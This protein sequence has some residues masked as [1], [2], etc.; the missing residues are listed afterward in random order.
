MA[1]AL[2]YYHNFKTIKDYGSGDEY[3]LEIYLEGYGGGSSELNAIE[4]N[5][6]ELSR[7]GDLLENVLGTKLTF[8]LWNETEGQFSEFRTAGWGDYMVKLIYDPSGVADEKFIGYNQ[9]E[10]YT[11]PYDQPPYQSKIEF[12]CGLSHLKHVRFDNSGT[13]YTG[14]KTIIEVLR[15]ALN[16][17]PNPVKI[18]EFVN[19]YEDSINSTTT[20][21]PFNQVYVDS[22]I[23]K[24]AK[25]DDDKNNEVGMFCYKVIEEIL[26]PFGA[27]IFTADGF[28]YIIRSQEYLDSTMYYREFNANVGTESTVTVDATGSFTTNNRSVTGRNGAANELVLQAQATEMSIDPP[29][30]RVKLTYDPTNLDIFESNLIKNGCW[31][32]TTKTPSGNTIKEVPDFWTIIGSSYLTY[33]SIITYVDK[34]Y[35]F[36]PTAQA[37]ATTADYNV[38]MSQ[39]KTGIPTFQTDSIQFS[40]DFVFVARVDYVA[41]GNVSN[42]PRNFLENNMEFNW[43]VELRFGSYYLSGDNVN[44]FSWTT[45]VSKA[46]FTRIGM[47]NFSSAIKQKF[48]LT[49]TLPTMPEDGLRDM[50]F[51][52]YRPYTNWASYAAT[53]SD[54]TMTFNILAQKCITLT[55]LPDELPPINE[56][57]L[58]SEI[59]E[60]ENLEDITTMHGDGTT[61]VSLN[62]YRLS[63]G[64]ITD[65]WNR[66][67]ISDSVGILKIL[68]YQLR[69][70]RS[71][72]LK[73]LSGRVIA[74]M[75]FYNTI[76][77]SAGGSVTYWMRTYSWSPELNEWDVDLMELRNDTGT[78]TT[79][80]QENTAIPVLLDTNDDS[81]AVDPN[82]P[83]STQ[84]IVVASTPIII[85][86]NNTNN[87]V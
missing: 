60:D 14:Q 55:Y 77:D 64:T 45:V 23:Y 30:N 6:I 84:S 71:Q 75:D 38:Y 11:E 83:I 39:S 12:T 13:L 35:Q 87:F 54:Y 86:Q 50:Y 7:D 66:R 68:L 28:W 46:K 25:D 52:L 37:T 56:L 19:L 27:H 79:I 70:M 43:E 2:K 63:D 53:N 59:D 69:D 32:I 15:L 9:S 44:G 21:S 67:G 82:D 34:Y 81:S 3:R 29:L 76:T 20:D 85:N 58:Y 18:R 1:Y 10:I 33:N 57:I 42:H 48:T 22:S 4:R 65:V 62:S 72:F 74:D 47:N 80:T 61:T 36:E 8:S 40:I 41:G 49:A 26:K 51:T 17:L 16:K 5:S 24:E 78:T 73:V 31:D